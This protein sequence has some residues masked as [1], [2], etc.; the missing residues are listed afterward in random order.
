MESA[1]LGS[2]AERYRALY[3]A[4]EVFLMRARDAATLT[5][6]YLMPPIG[7]N[8]AMQ[9]PTPYQSLGAR[10]VRNL[11]SKLLLALFPNTPFFKY[12]IDDFVLEQIKEKAQAAGANVKA[13]RGEFEIAMSRRE[14]AIMV[15][16][17]KAL[18]RVVAF[19]AFLHL[20]VAGNFLI[21]APPKGR[22]RG[23]R[24]DQ[25][26]VRRDP[27][28]EVLEIVVEEPINVDT[29]PPSFR[30]AVIKREIMTMG[31]DAATDDHKGV[32]EK[33][34]K[35]YTRIYRGTDDK[36]HIYQ[37]CEG[38]RI[39][40]SEGTYP[41]DQCPWLPL[42]WG[43]QP[44][45][46]YGRGYVEEFLGDL[47]SLES[48]SQTLVEGIAATARVL[49]LVNPNGVTRVKVVAEARNGDVR[50]GRAEDVT[51]VQ[52]ANKSAD[53]QTAQQQAEAIATRLSYAFML[54]SSI[55]RNGE[56]VT[57]EEIRYMAGDIDDALGGVY[58]LLAAEF[59]LP[60]VLIFERRMQKTRGVPA[61]PKGVAE[62]TIITGLE[63]IGRGNDLQA[64]KAFM[65]DVVQTVGP[66]VAFKYMKPG[67]FLQRTAA[68]YGID[69]TDLMAT[70][71]EVQQSEMQEQQNQVAQSLGPHAI[72][73]G[74]GLAQAAMKQQ[75]EQSGD[76]Q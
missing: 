21:Y 59:Q 31:A 23:F 9:L 16:I 56:R 20:I 68:A 57:A 42:R 28:G 14:R 25:Y 45:E 52:A 41:L 37:E 76:T 51:I 4:R 36:W 27:E 7:F 71:E 70:D 55:Q 40:G 53:F 15:E 75:G 32:G 72:K 74:A 22:V 61:L 65:S 13:S 60:V 29:L 5:M 69:T 17:N 1:A 63:A 73:A 64:M 43:S 35:L 8:P 33:T 19:T 18:L 38:L 47:D 67:E 46:D 10:G 44:C 6:P 3:S 39:D 50:S 30:L 12:E 62:P 58:T 26:V 34:S 66:E 48:L 24:L 11:A 54:N 2:A 49:F